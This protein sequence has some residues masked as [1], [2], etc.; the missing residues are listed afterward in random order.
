MTARCRADF[1]VVG[2]SFGFHLHVLFSSLLSRKV[3]FYS[4]EPPVTSNSS[5]RSKNGNS[6]AGLSQ[7]I[8][9]KAQAGRTVVQDFVPLAE[10]LEWELGQEYLRLRGNQAFLGDAFP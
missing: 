4:T 5:R 2:K 9:A 3:N 7:T 1:E 10:S 6:S 8:L